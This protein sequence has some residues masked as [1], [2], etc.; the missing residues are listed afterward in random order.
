MQQGLM[1]RFFLYGIGFG[2][3]SILV[4]VTFLRNPSG[5]YDMWTWG[6]R[7]KEEIRLDQTWRQRPLVACLLDC[8]QLE[9]AALDSLL[10]HGEVEIDGAAGDRDTLLY[11]IT[12]EAS[13]SQAGLRA[14][15]LWIRS[16][17]EARLV[18]LREGGDEA[19]CPCP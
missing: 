7:V 8:Q 1:R 2:I 19:A 3:G 12:T 11:T 14:D 9:L 17:K 5:D 16:R 18:T 4:Y 13:R 6:E 10:V 15:F